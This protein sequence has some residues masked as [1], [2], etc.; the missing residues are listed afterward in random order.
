MANFH[1]FFFL[2]KITDLICSLKIWKYLSKVV[3]IKDIITD[4]KEITHR[5]L[6][7]ERR[8]LCIMLI[9]LQNGRY[10]PNTL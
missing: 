6:K 4:I 8:K 7:K 3:A 5:I 1:L 10:S 9:P 2:H